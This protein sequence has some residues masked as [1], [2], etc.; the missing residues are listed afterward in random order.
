MYT[1]ISPPDFRI[2]HLALERSESK[3]SESTAAELS[4]RAIAYDTGFTL[5]PGK[6]TLKFLA[7]DAQTGRIGTYLTSFVIPNLNKEERKLPI[8]SV[9][10]SSQ[11]VSLGEALFSAG[12]DAVQSY[13]PLV[14][15]GEKLI[16]SVTRVFSRSKEMYVYLQAY[17][18][19]AAGL[20]PIVAFVSFYRGLS[21]VFETPLMRASEGLNNRLN[22]IPLKLRFAIDRLDPGEYTCQ[23]TVLQPDGHK[24]AFWRT[25]IMIV[26]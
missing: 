1:Y 23:T 12:K 19:D 16:P 2:N 5:L 8:S 24:A 17:Q 9:V 18:Q 13:S 22:T 4:R 14:Q 15:G 26:P 6:Y 21:K 20:K 3:L 7:R 11:S 10:L 25:Q